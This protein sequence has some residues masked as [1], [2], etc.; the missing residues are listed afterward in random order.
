LPH[1]EPTPKL[2]VCVECGPKPLEAFYVAYTTPK[3][4]VVFK[5]RCKECYPKVKSPNSIRLASERS[6]IQRASGHNKAAF[7]VKDSTRVD[8]D[9]GLT[10]DLT[11]EFVEEQLAKGC[12]YCDETDIR[13][14]GLD[15]VDNSL[16][17]TQHNVVPACERC[18]YIRR[19]MPYEAWLLF[20]PT[21][22]QVLDCGAFGEWYPN[23]AKLRKGIRREMP[24]DARLG[25]PLTE[26]LILA[27]A[28]TFFSVY[29][30][31]PKSTDKRPVVGKDV[32]WP[33]YDRALY[34]GLRGL[35]KGETTLAQLL[36]AE[37]GV[38]NRKGKR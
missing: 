25:A 23:N 18:N 30:E 20:V 13:W 3:G 34:Y 7:L 37:R 12:S 33:Y 6:K 21:L 28:D 9:K 8:R 4:A 10:C 29:G 22:R 2:K 19:D 31:W 1:C 15:R 17:H 11:K 26:A 14:L 38:P 27:D 36:Q 32:T 24:V 35:P 16:G 5:S